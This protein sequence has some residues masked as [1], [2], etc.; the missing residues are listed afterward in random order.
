MNKVSILEVGP[1]DGL[2]NE[3]SL[4]S[5]EEKREFV[6][7]LSH[8]GLNR[9]EVGSFVSPK[10]IPQMQDTGE[11]VRLVLQ[12]QKEGSIPQ[13]IQF[14]A[15][16][17]NEKGLH[18][19][20][21]S[22]LKEISIFLSATDSFSKKNINCP[23]QESYIKYKALCKKALKENLKIRAYLSVCFHCPY[24]GKVSQDKVLEWIK[25]LED[26]SVYEIAISD[27][28][29][30]A[31]AEEVQSLL[32]KILKFTSKD[33]LAC[34]F[35]NVHGMALANVWSAYRLGICKFDGSLGGLGGCPYSKSPSG[36]VAT[37]ALFYLLKK[38]EDN[39]IKKLIEIGLWLESKLKK[40]LPSR[41][42]HSPYYA[43]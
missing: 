4:L 43:K 20:L 22:G 30:Q 33:K 7:K 21:D 35:H 8:T 27:T 32:E 17:P 24:E 6:R 2:Q 13:H 37:E 38:S 34:H 9:I 15:L 19:A 11:L 25:K 5:L 41:L 10:W 40:K 31:N 39:S 3:Q 1:R 23:S 29:G 26:L 14:S 36:N 18:R 16:V 42:L 28:T 12:D